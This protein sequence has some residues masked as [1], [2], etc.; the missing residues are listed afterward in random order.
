MNFIY[1]QEPYLVNR[2]IAKL[3]KQS[4]D[5][6]TYFNQD[7]DIDFIIADLETVGMFSPS[8]LLVIKNH[9]MFSKTE[10]ATKMVASLMTKPESVEI[11][12]SLET[13]GLDKRNPLVKYL[14]QNAET[15]EFSRI[16]PNKLIPTIK[17]IV[18]SK[19]GTIT[20]SA[21]INFS[22]KVPNDLRLIILEIDK[23]I[24]ESNEITNE[25]VEISVSHY[26]K[27]DYFA[28]SN[29]LIASDVHGIVSAY[30]EKKRAG[31]EATM[32]I[33]Q[34]SSTLNL[35]IIVDAYKKQ[36]LTSADV[37]SKSGYHIFRVKKAFE[38]I[39]NS[40]IGTIKELLISL[41]TLDKDIKTG[42][43]P[44][45]KGLEVFLLKLI[46]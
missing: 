2:E 5:E 43:V 17:D 31:A 36:G 8:K 26:L 9:P 35:A 37:A 42:I 40:S 21:V 4:E 14:Q 11:L 39:S 27:D 22:K 30:Q 1:G 18:A 29:A 44:S 19:N 12:F 28:L 13:D 41:A 46:K 23:L 34:I 16:A 7:A 38:L 32:V 24:L 45:E 10:L 33:G 25:M 15:K 6:P 3:C 20:N